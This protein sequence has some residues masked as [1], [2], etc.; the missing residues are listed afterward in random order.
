MSNPNQSTASLS[1]QLT[2]TASDST[3]NLLPKQ[4]NQ[5]SSST[6]KPTTTTYP[7]PANQPPKNYEAAFASLSSSYGFSASAPMKPKKKKK[8]DKAKAASSAGQSS[9]ANT[10]ASSQSTAKK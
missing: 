3:T 7:V 9:S 1:S 4:G 2:S 6:V 5:V 10:S 8:E